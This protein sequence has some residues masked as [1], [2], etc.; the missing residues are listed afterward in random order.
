MF[1]H[2]RVVRTL[3]DILVQRL[4]FSVKIRVDPL[5]S[6]NRVD[7]RWFPSTQYANLDSMSWQLT[8]LLYFCRGR[9]L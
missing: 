1:L 3:K 5:T 7:T 8:Q 6:L 2:D 9:V 4:F